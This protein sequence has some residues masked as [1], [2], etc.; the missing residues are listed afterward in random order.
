VQLTYLPF[1]G[2]Q[3]LLSGEKKEDQL[4]FVLPPLERGA[5]VWVGKGE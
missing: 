5:V 1:L 2:K 4:E 3:Q